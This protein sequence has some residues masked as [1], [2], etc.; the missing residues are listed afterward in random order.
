ML[1]YIGLFCT[2]LGMYL[3][4]RKFMSCWAVWIIGDALWII[5]YLPRHDWA[6]IA[7]NVI[8]VGLN[9]WGWRAWSKSR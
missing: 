4:G 7:T 2:V 5:A 8:F 6:I 3:N 9:I 1:E